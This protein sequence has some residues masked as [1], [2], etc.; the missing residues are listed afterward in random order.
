VKFFIHP[1]GGVILLPKLPVS[2]LLDMLKSLRR[3]PVT[4]EK[5]ARASRR[6][7]VGGKLRRGPVSQLFDGPK[8]REQVKSAS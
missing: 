6:F 8:R 7:K 4:I 2:T 3:R 5:K 1:N